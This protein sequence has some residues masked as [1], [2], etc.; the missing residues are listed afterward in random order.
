MHRIL[1]LAVQRQQKCV[2]YCAHSVSLPALSPSLTTNA[3]RGQKHEWA[4]CGVCVVSCDMFW[5]SVCTLLYATI[6]LG[7]ARRRCVMMIFC[8]VISLSLGARRSVVWMHTIRGGSISFFRNDAVE[9]NYNHLPV[10]A[11][12]A[13]WRGCLFVCFFCG[14]ILFWYIFFSRYLFMGRN[15]NDEHGLLF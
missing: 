10:G 2:E 9:P 7:C 4:A 14:G 15:G 12:Y 5:F 8:D 6:Q 1:R 13:L 11:I 3:C